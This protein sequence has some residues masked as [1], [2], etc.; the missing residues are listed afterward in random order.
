MSRSREADGKT[1]RQ[2]DD[3]SDVTVRAAA[4]GSSACPATQDQGRLVSATA[5]EERG[6]HGWNR[7]ANARLVVFV[8]AAAAAA[9][10]LWGRAPFGWALAGLMLGLFVALAVYHSRLG[11]ERRR[12]G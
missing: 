7:V 3:K 1:A 6:H 9:W 5:G 2:R 10:G 11:W 12:L 4:D 8:A